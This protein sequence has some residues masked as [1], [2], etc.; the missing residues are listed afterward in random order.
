M[1]QDIKSI[2]LDAICIDGTAKLYTDI[3]KLIIAFAHLGDKF[4]NDRNK[5]D[6]SLK[7]TLHT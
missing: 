6:R 2:L 5:L 7:V 1:A 3:Y 4:Y